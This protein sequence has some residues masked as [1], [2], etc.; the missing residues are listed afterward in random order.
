MGWRF[1]VVAV[2][3]ALLE[4]LVHFLGKKEGKVVVCFF[5]LRVGFSSV[6]E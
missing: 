1:R 5:L 4:A 6:M 2:V 3:A